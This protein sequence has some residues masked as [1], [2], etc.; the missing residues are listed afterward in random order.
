MMDVPHARQQMAR[1][2]SYVTGLV[3]QKLLLQN[4]YLAAENRIL[5]ALSVDKWP[6]LRKISNL[7][8]RSVRP[9]KLRYGVLQG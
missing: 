2:L 5:R 9:T 4:E 1:L 7:R 6:R 3:N 8:F